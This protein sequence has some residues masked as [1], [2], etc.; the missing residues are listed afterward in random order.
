MPSRK[1]GHERMTS[2]EEEQ[3]VSSF[4]DDLDAVAR[5]IAAD[6]GEP[7]DAHPM[8]DAEKVKAWGLRD[9][10]ADPATLLP[11]LL[12][13]GLGPEEANQMAIV[14]EWPELADL[15]ANPAPDHRTADQLVRLAEFPFRRGIL[16]D[17][18]DDPEAWTKEAERLERLWN[19]GQPSLPRDEAPGIDTSTPPAVVPSA[20]APEMPT[21]AAPVDTAA[22]QTPPAPVAPE[23]GG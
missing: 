1:L 21:P 4:L 2:S 13:T 3:V 18:E 20:P 19:K 12:A 15:Y 22:P 7:P 14:Q 16:A 6:Q 9:R 11:R 17:L 23:I 8:G 10:R 5:R